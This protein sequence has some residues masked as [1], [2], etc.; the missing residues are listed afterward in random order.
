NSTTNETLCG[1]SEGNWSTQRFIII[2]ACSIVASVGVL[3]NLILLAVFRRSLPSS[4]FLAGL[5]LLDALLCLTYVLL[6]GVDASFNYLESQILFRLYHEYLKFVFFLCKVVQFAMPYMLILATL[7]RF[8]WTAGDKMRHLL[9]CL[10]SDQGRQVTAMAIILISVAFRLI[11]YFSFEISSFPLCPNLFA[12]ISPV[13]A[14]FIGHEYYMIFDLQIVTTLQTVIPFIVLLVLNAMIIIKMCGEKRDQGIINRMHAAAE[15]VRAEREAIQRE[16][17]EVC[18]QHMVKKASIIA[19]NSTLPEHYV[20]MEVA[21][22]MVQES[23]NSKTNREKAIQLRNA[24][25]T[26]LVIVLSY[27]ICNGLNLYLLYF[28][29]FAPKALFEVDDPTISSNFYVA[30]S[31]TVS[32]SYMLSS[33]VRLFIYAKCNPKLRKELKQYLWGVEYVPTSDDDSMPMLQPFFKLPLKFILGSLL[34]SAVIARPGTNDNY[35]QQF[36]TQSGADHTPAYSSN[37]GFDYGSGSTGSHKIGTG[38]SGSHAIGSGAVPSFTDSVLTKSTEIT[39][40]LMCGEEPARDVVVRLYRN[41]T[42]II[43]NLLT[44]VK[45]K[46]DGSFRIEGNTAGKGADETGIKGHRTFGFT[47]EDP[48]YVTLGRISRKPFDIGKLN[49][50]MIY[51]GEKREMKFTNDM[52]L[53]API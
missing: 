36:K 11:V 35:G 18:T 32:I 26:M 24:V 27:L 1:Y 40:I 10:F 29:K 20:L 33:A 45:T 39:G 14:E 37:R 47:V 53:G 5:S 6:F 12:S 2:F 44:V 13:P 34:I 8:T 3:C 42:E 46:D 9:E 28:E 15:E 21:N 4:V 16:K 25:I 19:N 31:D 48:M 52:P 38:A 43:E 22:G 51:P 49:I 41:T 30:L 7:E 23:Y 50:Q 17:E